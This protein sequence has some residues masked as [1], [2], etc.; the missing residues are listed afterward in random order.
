MIDL[1]LS[2]ELQSR[3]IDPKF[4]QV[5]QSETLHY[6]LTDTMKIRYST[7]EKLLE[8]LKSYAAQIIAQRKEKKGVNGSSSTQKEHT[9]I[10][11]KENLPN[12]YV[13]VQKAPPDLPDHYSIY[14]ANA[15]GDMN[16]M[17]FRPL[18]W[19]DGRTNNYY[20]EMFMGVC[21]F[22]Q[23]RDG[24]W[25]WTTDEETAEMHRQWAKLDVQELTPSTS[26][27]KSRNRF[28]EASANI[29][30]GWRGNGLSVWLHW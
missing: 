3:L 2:D 23:K 28:I 22:D 17:P 6:W 10:A 24:E 26:E 14:A 27:C 29:R 9:A 15:V 1:G 19:D 16:Q 5:F 11:F 21:N 4:S 30:C 25:N 18:V 8:P 12:G 20:I 13:P 7:L